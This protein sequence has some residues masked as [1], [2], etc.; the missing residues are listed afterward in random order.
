MLTYAHSGVQR[1]RVLKPFKILVVVGQSLLSL[2]V[3]DKIVL[4]KCMQ[5]KWFYKRKC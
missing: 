1:L 5:Q 2:V 3:D 4:N